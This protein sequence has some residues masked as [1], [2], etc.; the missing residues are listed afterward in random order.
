MGV[1]V[2]A[3]LFVLSICSRMLATLCLMV[4]GLVGGLV[5]WLVIW[6]VGW[7]VGPCHLILYFVLCC[8][9]ACRDLL[10]PLPNRT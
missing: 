1:A 4:G 2:C 5:G 6:L 9:K 8:F 10:R 7:S 3:L